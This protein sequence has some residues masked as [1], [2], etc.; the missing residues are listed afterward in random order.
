[1]LSVVICVT[2]HNT[3]VMSCGPEYLSFVIQIACIYKC[4][5]TTSLG[6]ESICTPDAIRHFLS[7]K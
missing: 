2:T 4:L 6:F 3:E 5:K 1:M 7:E